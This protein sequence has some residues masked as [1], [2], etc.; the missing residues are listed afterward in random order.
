LVITNMDAGGPQVDD[1]DVGRHLPVS[2][3]V[4]LILL[5]LTGEAMHG[6]GM[7]LAI[8]ERTGGRVRLGTGTLYSAIKR[9]RAD[10]LVEEAP[11]PTDSEDPRRKYYRLT[12][13]GLG[14]VR[15]EAD[16]HARLAD[17]ARAEGLLRT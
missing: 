7:L 3:Q 17:L 6:Y 16:R 9:L 15:A 11:T 4:F 12:R 14:V 1:L 8:E 13:L 10:G 5:S 2:E